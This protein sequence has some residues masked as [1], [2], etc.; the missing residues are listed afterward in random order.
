MTVISGEIQG[1][2]DTFPETAAYVY[3]SGILD[4][5]LPVFTTCS[6]DILQYVG[7]KSAVNQCKVMQDDATSGSETSD[8]SGW[9]SIIFWIG[10]WADCSKSFCPGC[11]SESVKCRE[12]ILGWDNGLGV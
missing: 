3:R 12:L 8:S 4:R 1:L 9:Y 5:D 6:T 10:G 2:A 7:D 11:I